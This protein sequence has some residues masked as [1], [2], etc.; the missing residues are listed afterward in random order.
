MDDPS[1]RSS[2]LLS[3]P[4][5]SRE[6]SPTN[7]SSI[8]QHAESSLD[9]DGSAADGDDDGARSDISNGDFGPK[10]TASQTFIHLLKGYIGAGCLSLPWAVSQ[11]GFVGGTIAIAVMSFWSSY[12]CWTIVK[13]KRYIERSSLQ[14]ANI[15]DEAETKSESASAS[16]MASSALTYPDVGEWAYGDKFEQFISGC[17]ITQQ[18]A[19]C[20]VFF[21]FVGENIL[22]VCQLVPE[23]VP[24]ILL[25]H[26]GVMTVAF[27]F[28]LGLSFIPNLSAL[29]PV[30]T[31]GTVL[32]FSGFGV[33]GYVIYAEW[34]ERP[35]NPV[36]V[37]WKEAPLALCA[38]LYSYEGICLI[39]PI[40]SCM[41][42][43][44]KFK[45]IFGAAMACVAILMAIVA[46]LC[47]MAFGEVTNGS[48]TAFLLEKYKDDKSVIV[49]LM[50]ANMAISLSVL[51][52]Y[53]LQL[54]PTL[55]LVGPKV[56][57]LW[58]K[59]RHG[60]KRGEG[61]AIEDNENDLTGFDPMP[62]L[63]EH[64]VVS[65]SSFDNEHL[66]ENLGNE[67]DDAPPIINGAV[68]GEEIF[69]PR[70][71]MTSQLTE[72]FPTLSIPGDS[73]FLRTGLVLVTYLV[74]VI[75]P[76]VQVLISLAGAIA[77]SSTALLI[78]PML[79]LALID[80]LESKP[81]ITVSPK[82]FHPSQENTPNTSSFRRLCRFDLSGKFWK[83]KLK[84]FFLF[85]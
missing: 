83:K 71:S 84:C 78:P 58:W 72:A 15:I 36:E 20:T 45:K 9:Y 7:Y 25:S 11:V 13:I 14:R 4:V 16:S 1:S 67:T 66:Y 6:G 26:I 18:L 48:V 5:L 82:P 63:H 42:E 68:S 22:A 28:I 23:I 51:F 85:W 40:E 38:V 75:I 24:S 30:L 56:A 62:T 50:I 49:F 79:E 19:I 21:S 41:A 27:P 46:N 74:A 64:D 37:Q 52:T 69:D 70:G 80:H 10:T 53:P 61:G 60:G 8:E 33:L 54:F 77:G 35:V 29:T 76:N 44:K 3:S 12:N 47:V 57:A 32:L 73:L 43:P 2:P 17:I 81:D 59:F 65:L 55:E 39:L 31:M 34:D